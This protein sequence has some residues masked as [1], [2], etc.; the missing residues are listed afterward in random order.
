MGSSFPVKQRRPLADAGLDSRLNRIERDGSDQRLSL[1]RHALRFMPDL[2]IGAADGAWDMAKG[3]G[4]LIFHP[5]RTAKGIWTLA[6]KLV[7]EPGPTLK[8]IGA[9]IVDPYLAA[10]EAGHP[11]QAVGR[12]IVEIGSLFVQPGDVVNLVRGGN[13]FAHTAYAGLKAGESVSRTL[14]AATQAGRYSMQAT[15]AARDAQ[16]LAKLGHANEAIVMAEYASHALRV[17]K[18][19]MGG[20]LEAMQAAARALEATRPVLIGGKSV[21]LGDFLARSSKLLGV[22]RF[23]VVSGHLSSDLYQ[24]ASEAEKART[25][26]RLS[27]QILAAGAR[28]PT[29]LQKIGRLATRNPQVFAPF[30]P[31]LGKIAD[32]MGRMNSLPQNLPGKEGLTPEAARDIAFKYNLEP[33]IGNVQAFIAE[34]SGY[35]GNTI[36]PDT[37]SA[38][39]VKQLQVLL[40]GAQY[41]VTA[42]GVWDRATAAAVIDFKRKHGIFQSYRLANGEQACNEYADERVLNALLGVIEGLAGK[43][44]AQPGARSTGTRVAVASASAANAPGR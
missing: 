40:K 22:R 38:E 14:G 34:V 3:V 43:A 17:T 42:T 2:F 13:A 37:G 12:G 19:A 23:S 41:D 35:E 9:A 15:R 26:V 36:G 44:G 11:G 20:K 16:L 6:T 30:T 5:V 7:S 31:A 39:Q 25:A 33:S 18:L 1:G 24:I 29:L 8:A 10:I 32:A 21:A 28:K 27:E 4:T